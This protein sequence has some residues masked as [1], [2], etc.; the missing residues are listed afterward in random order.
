MINC[1][2]NKNL[3]KKNSTQLNKIYL[4]YKY[5][6]LVCKSNYQNRKINVII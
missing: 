2:L 4:H 6:S 3:L 5:N 1:Y